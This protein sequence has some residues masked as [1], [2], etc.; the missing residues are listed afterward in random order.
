MAATTLLPEKLNVG[1]R[2]SVDLRGSPEA[3]RS[4]QQ[5]VSAVSS[6]WADGLT[7]PAN[8]PAGQRSA[9]PQAAHESVTARNRGGPGSVSDLPCTPAMAGSGPRRLVL[10]AVTAALAVAAPAVAQTR[11]TPPAEHTAYAREISEASARYAVP[12]RLIW[13]VIR[14]ESGFDRRAVSPRGARGLMQL[15]PE[16]AAILGVRD[17]FDAR[18]NIHG[19]TRHLR[20][21]MERFRNNPR[22][23]VAAYNAGE[24]AVVEYGGVPPY[25]ETQEYVTRVLRFYGDASASW[26]DDLPRPAGGRRALGGGVYRFARTDGT[27]VYTNIPYGQSVALSRSR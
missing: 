15:M 9:R 13:A 4:T 17:A 19:G 25:P 26:A 21:M 2:A 22:L 20:A 27:I 7:A 14:V 10:L 18:Q 11:Q 3:R 23:A 6:T 5:F 12:E 24:R 1:Q 8:H 16:T